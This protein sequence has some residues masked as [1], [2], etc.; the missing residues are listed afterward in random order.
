MSSFRSLNQVSLLSIVKLT[1]IIILI[2][3]L[4]L[5][6]V[7]N[8]IVIIILITIIVLLSIVN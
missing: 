2:T 3:I 4:I 5:L 8:L 6:S 7:A 1:I